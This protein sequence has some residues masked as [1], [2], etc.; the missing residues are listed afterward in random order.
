MNLV[1]VGFVIV[2]M[3]VLFDEIVDV[4]VLCYIGDGIGQDV[5]DGI[6]DVFV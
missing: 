5:V 1:E 2:L 3:C 4:G 6:S